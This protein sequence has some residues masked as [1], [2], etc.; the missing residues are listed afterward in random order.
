[1]YDRRQFLERQSAYWAEQAAWNNR[2]LTQYI[3]LARG[4]REMGREDIAAKIDET[5][6]IAMDL[7]VKC[8]EWSHADAEKA[9]AL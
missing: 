9:A 4:Y 7:V 6:V 5:A 1:M 2:M 8:T 3:D